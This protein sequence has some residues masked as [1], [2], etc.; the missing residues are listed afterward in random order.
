M[1]AG[2]VMAILL[3]EP[4]VIVGTAAFAGNLI[5]AAINYLLKHDFSDWV[6]AFH[7]Y[8][9]EKFPGSTSQS[10][11]EAVGRIEQGAVDA[12]DLKEQLETISNVRDACAKQKSV[13]PETLQQIVTAHDGEKHCGVPGCGAPG[14]NK[15]S[16]KEGHPRWH[17]HSEHMAAQ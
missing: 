11:E 14:V 17:V 10:S 4:L 1:A 7:K 8:T 12:N 3:G 6:P 16:H 15:S 9:K 13:A 2:A 5:A